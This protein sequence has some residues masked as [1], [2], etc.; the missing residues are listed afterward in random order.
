MRERKYR[1]RIPVTDDRYP[2][3]ADYGFIADCHSAALVS[4]C[5][6]IDWCCM[7]RFD[8]SS[9][10]GR[11][12]GWDRDGHCSVTAEGLEES[13]ERRYVDG[14]LV[15]E[16]T[17][18]TGE[19]EARLRDCF[20]M[21]EGGARDPR[22]QLLRVFD[23][24]RGT[25]RLRVE[26][27]P[28]FDYGEVRPWIRREARGLFSAIGGDDGLL[29][30]TDGSIEPGD[31]HDLQVELELR[32]G[33]RARVSIA[34]AAPD[35][36]DDFDPQPLEPAE[37]DERLDYTLEWWRRWEASAHGEVDGAIRSAAV[38]RGLQHA[39]TGA[40]AAA[41]TT[42]LPER[43][44]GVR[45]WDYR[46][47][48]IRDSA[49]SAR[50]LAELGFSSEADHFRR[51]AQRSSAGNVE[52]L[53]VFY[54]IGGERRLDESELDLEGYR[55][56]RPVRVGNG[57]RDQLQLDAYG[58][59][60]GVTW[61]WHKRGHSPDDDTWRF[62]L[63]LVDAAA[64]RWR[65]PDCGIWEWR[66]DPLHFVHSKVM[67]WSAL[68]R[69]LKLA[70]ECDRD[71]PLDRWRE[72]RDEIREAVESEGYDAERGTFVQ[73]FGSRRMDAALLLLPSHDFVAYDDERMVRTVDAVREE[74]GDNGLL[75]RY[76]QD[77]GLGGDEGAFLACSFWLAE[78]LVKQGRPEEAREA[79]DRALETGND[80]GL[81]AEECD[82]GTGQLLGNFP[83]ALTHLSHISAAVAL[84]ST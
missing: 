40:I 55:G 70:E 62:V 53:Q 82:P 61:R 9:C 5:G 45:N 49:F 42:S 59:L 79:F 48:W 75:R 17:L 25:V 77:D 26:V 12:I 72:A 78:C 35:E 81:F 56:S 8:S 27:V 14:S 20:T 46:Y 60:I 80:L 54:G 58:E 30:W 21:R 2:P 83:Q 74:L 67:C 31:D 66:G 22:R 28:R 76:R 39:A 47:S 50:S 24:V 13:P 3:I 23:G 33:E 15:L 68:D 84:S 44:G 71:G 36:I 34:Y 37:L 63:E 69:G 1:R 6:S 10:F 38:L 11:L 32:E 43:I 52:D 51:F 29:V 7:P 64:E 65:E 16:T 4:R 18:R 19:G 41:A 73:A 57:A